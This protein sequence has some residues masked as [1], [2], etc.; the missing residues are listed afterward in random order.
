MEEQEIKNRILNGSEELFMRYGVR[1]I[2]MDDIAR[3]LGVSKKTLYQHFS[4]KDD[5]VT[6]VS[7]AHFERDARLFRQLKAEAKNAIEELAKLWVWIKEDLEKMNPALLMDIQKYHPK[8][9]RHWMQYKEEFVRESM[10]LNID[11]GK[12]EGYFRPE[13]NAEII[14][15][16]RLLLLEAAFNDRYFPRDTF[17]L[18]DIQSQLFELFVYGL[19]T[20]KGRQLYEQY[21]QSYT[22]SLHPI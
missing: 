20:D 19:C 14:A 15:T 11:Q 8:A 6:R 13:V 18:V 12:R 4:D 10:V 22:P 9:F 16:S 21:K 1:S 7:R 17:N 2:S 3:H 5:L